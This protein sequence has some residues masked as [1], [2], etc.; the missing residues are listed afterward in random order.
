MS[1]ELT[2]KNLVDIA[3]S[4]VLNNAS[5]GVAIK[6]LNAVSERPDVIGFGGWCRSVLV[7]CKAT[8]SDFLGDKR[9]LFRKH[10]ERG[11]GQYRY[12]M[13]PTGLINKEELPEKW[14]LIYVNEKGKA[15]IYHNPYNDKGGNI[16]YD[17][18]T[19][20]NQESEMRLMYSV[21]RRL[22]LRGR[23]EEIYEPLD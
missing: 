10:P 15:R 23:I 16:W 12:Y 4:W 8:R 11:M 3:Y 5:C 17:G 7:E 9:K 2:H 22:E 14:G 6:E 21:L 13:C 20:R 18:F 19:E 1:K